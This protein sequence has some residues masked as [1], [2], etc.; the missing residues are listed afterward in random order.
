M[1]D[2][3][4]GSKAR[5]KI[6]TLFLSHPPRQLHMRE[7][8][9][10]LHLSIN[11]VRYELLHLKKIGFLKAKR[12]GTKRFFWPNPDFAILAE[13]R[14]IILKLKGEGNQFKDRIK[15]LGDVKLALLLGAF[16]K[17]QAPIDLLLVGAISKQ[18]FKKTL[19]FFE[20][21]M[22]REINWTILTEKEF[23]ERMMCRDKFL[24]EVFSKPKVVVIDNLGLF[25]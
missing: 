18:R 24:F 17:S 3:L 19:P 9:R 23:Q 4:F 15:K 20:K 21:E 14:N 1:L 16:T 11:A 2:K 5:A 25:G 22:N 13:L 8:S 7:I 10:K 6:I 12:Q